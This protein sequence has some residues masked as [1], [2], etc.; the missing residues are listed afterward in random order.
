MSSEVTLKD[1]TARP[2]REVLMMQGGTGGSSSNPVSADH[3]ANNVKFIVDSGAS[4]HAAGNR[5]VFSDITA[6]LELEG[7][8]LRMANGSTLTVEGCGTV[9]HDNIALHDVMFAPGLDINA[10]SVSK[11]GEQGY[12]V[13]F[14]RT[15]CFIRDA[16]T[17]EL[18]GKGHL[19]DGLYELDFL[20]APRAY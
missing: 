15:T 1:L 12:T 7:T 14:T 10:A 8:E 16:S 13:E 2:A 17:G 9:R 20:E 11:L 3:D 19:V 6:V 4:V 18:V 5:G